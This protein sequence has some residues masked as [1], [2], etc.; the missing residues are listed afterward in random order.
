MEIKITNGTVKIK[1]FISRKIQKEFKSKLLEGVILTQ[2]LDPND[3][4]ISANNAENANDALVINMIESIKINEKNIEVT[5]DSVLNLID[6][7]FNL[8]LGKCLEIMNKKEDDK[9]K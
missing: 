8:V 5:E 2:N 1:D 4:P 3:I 7:D 6:A 9:K